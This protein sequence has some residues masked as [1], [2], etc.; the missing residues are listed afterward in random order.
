MF[1][2]FS[3][4]ERKEP[5]LSSVDVPTSTVMQGPSHGVRWGGAAAAWLGVGA[6]HGNL[7]FSTGEELLPPPA[8]LWLNTGPLDE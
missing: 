5:G 7:W 4:R 6:G 1:I 2:S 3:S 8:R